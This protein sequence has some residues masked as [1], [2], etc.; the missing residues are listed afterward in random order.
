MSRC[1]YA[2]R[3]YALYML[4]V[5][6]YQQSR[7]HGDV[8]MSKDTSHANAATFR[9]DSGADEH[10]PKDCTVA[11][12]EYPRGWRRR[13][14]RS[15]RKQLRGQV[16]PRLLGSPRKFAP[17]DPSGSAVA[18]CRH[19]NDI[20]AGELRLNAQK[21]RSWSQC[22]RRLYTAAEKKALERSAPHR[23]IAVL[24]GWSAEGNGRAQQ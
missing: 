14:P 10:A 12:S 15:E 22:S 17:K 1:G 11:L 24:V 8:D 2:L 4:E 13:R 16:S 5:T 21:S 9:G 3:S 6:T 19:K 18:A 7:F 20:M 23:S